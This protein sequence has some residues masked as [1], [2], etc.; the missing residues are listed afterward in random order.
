MKTAYIAIGLACALAMGV[1]G[2]NKDRE[3]KATTGTAS[4]TIKTDAP[5][6]EV[7]PAQLQTQAVEAATAASKPVD[8]SGPVT[9]TTPAPVAPAAKELFISE[10]P[11]AGG[12]QAGVQVGSA[13]IKLLHSLGS[14]PARGHSVVWETLVT[15]EAAGR[16]CPA[17]RRGWP[18]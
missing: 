13:E 1:S 17:C 8:G 11:R 16:G 3:A 14:P 4:A 18:G 9:T 2:C 5:A 12:D 7:P 10:Y 6:S 15:T